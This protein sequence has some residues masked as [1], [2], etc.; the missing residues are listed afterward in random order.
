MNT[1]R[2][3]ILM[4]VHHELVAAAELPEPTRPYSVQSRLEK[5]QVEII[6]EIEQKEQPPAPTAKTTDD[7]PF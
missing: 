3:Q 4:A 6:K 1:N 5:L 2:L 7:I